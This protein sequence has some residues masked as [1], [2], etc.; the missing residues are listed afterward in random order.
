VGALQVNSTEENRH[1]GIISD[2]RS[3]IRQLLK[4]YYF[5]EQNKTKKKFQGEG[6]DITFYGLGGSFLT[7]FFFMVDFFFPIFPRMERS[8]KNKINHLSIVFSGM[9]SVSGLGN[10]GHGEKGVGRS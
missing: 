9:S 2:S 8:E 1:L 5:Q 7:F 10:K 3:T 6:K 4:K